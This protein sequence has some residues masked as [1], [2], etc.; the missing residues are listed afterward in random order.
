MF[1]ARLACLV[2]VVAIAFVQR[3]TVN[4]RYLAA[5]LAYLFADFAL[6]FVGASFHRQ[7]LPALDWNWTGKLLSIAFSVTVLVLFRDLRKD[8]GATLKQAH[9]RLALG[10]VLLLVVAAVATASGE[11]RPFELEDLLYMGTMPALSEE[12][13]FR[14]IGMALFTRALGNLGTVGGTPVGWGIAVTTIA[15]GAVHGVFVDHGVIQVSWIRFLETGAVGVVLGFVRLISGSLL[16]PVI[17]HGLANVAP[18]LRYG[19]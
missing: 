4:L 3:R 2:P 8:A 12:L 9:P 17:G 16:L 14:G 7:F 5:A 18:M 11:P 19:Q 10:T 13:A 6:T 15:F 1:A